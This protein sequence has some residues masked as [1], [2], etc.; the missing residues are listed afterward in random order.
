MSAEAQAF[1]A[2][3]VMSAEAVTAGRVVDTAADRATSVQGTDPPST[4]TEPSKQ[5]SLSQCPLNV[6]NDISS[7]NKTSESDSHLGT[8]LAE[9]ETAAEETVSSKSEAN[10]A[11]TITTHTSS[12]VVSANVVAKQG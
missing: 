12:K 10:A 7:S 4:E 5:S 6:N 1:S 8:P 2:A 9:T 3:P 11:L